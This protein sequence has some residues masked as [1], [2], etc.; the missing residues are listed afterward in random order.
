MSVDLVVA[1]PTY[2]D[3][4]FVGLEALPQLG[5]E[6]FA[7]DLVRSPGGGGIIAV[8]AARLG[9]SVTLA[10]PLG[11]DPAGD[12]I[13]QA[14]AA[15]GIATVDR[16]CRRTPITVVMPVAGDRAMVTVDEGVRASSAD[17]AALA[18]RA[19]AVSLDLLFCVP[20]GSAAYVTCGEDDARAYAARPP[21]ALEGARALFV[22]SEEALA[23][24]GL[25][26]VESAGRKLARVTH[27]VVLTR[28]AAGALGYTGG[29]R[30]E[31]AGVDVGPV[32]D[33][34]GAGDLLAAAYVWAD[35]SGAEPEECLRWAVLYASLS[36]AA[37][38]GVGGAATADRLLTEGARL[39]YPPIA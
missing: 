25:G 30:Y 10:A 19:V 34:T 32:R 20:S 37:S 21:A 8:G 27:T 35:L 6:R 12:L 11:A 16:R 31:I 17:V 7:G 24:T 39:G 36:V 15:E 1:T 14:L 3:L 9:L 5:E 23:L 38:T 22:N 18:P 13:R 26:D 4:T 28:G 29:R 33:P 2:L